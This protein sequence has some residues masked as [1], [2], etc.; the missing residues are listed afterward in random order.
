MNECMNQ[1]LLSKKLMVSAVSPGQVSLQREVAAGK[2]CTL[3]QLALLLQTA[4][5]VPG[6]DGFPVHTDMVMAYML[7]AERCESEKL[8]C[9]KSWPQASRPTAAEQEVGPL[10]VAAS[11][12]HT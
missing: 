6:K 3:I 2:P 5:S 10:T 1:V 9:L 12:A 8:P 4:V 7:A 11:L